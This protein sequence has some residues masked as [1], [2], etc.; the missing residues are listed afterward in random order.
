M[1]GIKIS[2]MVCILFLYNSAPKDTARDIIDYSRLSP[3]MVSKSL[4]ALREAGYVAGSRDRDDGRYIHL[5]LTSKADTIL[6]KLS[7]AQTEFITC[8]AEGISKEDFDQMCHVAE[9]MGQNIEDNPKLNIS[10]S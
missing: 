6:E 5:R 1:E 2:E 10:L 4:E 7:K 3:G 9:I 8:I